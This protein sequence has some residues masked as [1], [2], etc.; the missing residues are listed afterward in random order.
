MN[1]LTS[2]SS[3]R[4][5]VAMKL[6]STPCIPLDR[7]KIRKVDALLHGSGIQCNDFMKIED[8]K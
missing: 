5:T 1:K 7:G 3:I 4:E 8:I 6:K 2:F